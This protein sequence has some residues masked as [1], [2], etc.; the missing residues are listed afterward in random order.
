MNFLLSVA[1]GK[2]GLKSKKVEGD[3][4]TPKGSY[5]LKKLYYRSDKFKKIET[6]TSKNK[7]KK[8]YGLVQ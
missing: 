6:C 4:A 7:N 1:I 8:K 3:L 5:L 2:N